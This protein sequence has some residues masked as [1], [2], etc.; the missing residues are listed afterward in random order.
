MLSKSDISI[1]HK[2]E[3]PIMKKQGMHGS[4]IKHGDDNKRTRSKNGA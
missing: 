4:M 3:R 1:L 2:N